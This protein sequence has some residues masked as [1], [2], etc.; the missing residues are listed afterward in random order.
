M[1]AGPIRYQNTHHSHFVTF[2][3]YHR[4]AHLD[5]SAMRDL[6]VYCLEQTRL[7]YRF[8]VYGYVVMPEH[9]HLLVSEP[10]T[11]L[12]ATALQ[13]LKDLLLPPRALGG[14]ARA[15]AVLAEALF[16]SQCS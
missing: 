10:D 3:C 14:M 1:P 16:R 8:C 2:S 6:F 15:A 4:L 13:A 9:V 12:L 5:S 11:G 7:H